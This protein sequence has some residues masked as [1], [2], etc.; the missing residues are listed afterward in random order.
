MDKSETKV[1]QEEGSAKVP[2]QKTLGKKANVARGEREI[3]REGEREGGRG[4]GRRGEGEGEGEGRGIG[5]M[6][7]YKVKEIV[8]GPVITES[9]RP[10]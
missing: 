5:R 4:G 2:R 9:C 10:A 6:V 3:K 8:Q 1:F 7:G